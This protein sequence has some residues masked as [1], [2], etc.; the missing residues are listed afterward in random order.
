MLGIMIS[1]GAIDFFGDANALRH[2]ACRKVLIVLLAK[3][4]IALC[5]LYG[6]FW[7]VHEDGS[8]PLCINGLYIHILIHLVYSFFIFIFFFLLRTNIKMVQEDLAIS[9][10]GLYY[11][12]FPKQYC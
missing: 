9:P 2:P 1:I 8:L 4:W 3:L 11:S 6:C 5:V 10:G 12:Y 7:L